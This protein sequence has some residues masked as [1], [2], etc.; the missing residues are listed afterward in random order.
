MD[1]KQEAMPMRFEEVVCQ[2]RPLLEKL[3]GGPA[4]HGQTLRKLPAKG[5]YVFYE[6]GKPM[7][8]GRVGSN[9]KQTV[10]QRIRNTRSQAQGIIRRPSRSGYFRKTLTWQ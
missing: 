2:L 3:Q 10:R 9:S 1:E 4:Y 5:V 6:K 7:Y 8:V